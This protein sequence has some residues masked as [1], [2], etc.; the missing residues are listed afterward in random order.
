MSYD[1]RTQNLL[2]K[3]LKKPIMDI[4]KKFRQNNRLFNR[5]LNAVH[6]MTTFLFL[7]ESGKTSL[8]MS[9]APNTIWDIIS[10]ILLENW[11]VMQTAVTEKQMEQFIGDDTSEA[12]VYVHERRR[13]YL[14]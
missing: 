10:Q 5:D 9:T 11:N 14:H 8:Q 3:T 7:K 2:Q 1:A 6:L 4:C 13:R 12:E